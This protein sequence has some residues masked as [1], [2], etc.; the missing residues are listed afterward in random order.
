MIGS[1][2]CL[3]RETA[4]DA[5]RTVGTF[6]GTATLQLDAD[7]KLTA[8]VV[9]DGTRSRVELAGRWTGDAKRMILELAA[10]TLN[11][12]LVRGKLL[13]SS[14]TSGNREAS[15]STSWTCTKPAEAE[16]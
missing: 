9:P 12:S 8:K 11:G 5:N 14:A 16:R 3:T 10:G 13:L 4:R 1:W 15:V 2:E 7:Q 6:R